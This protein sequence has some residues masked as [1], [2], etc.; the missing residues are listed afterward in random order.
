MT[1]TT[2]SADLVALVHPDLT[3][4][5]QNDL[6]RMIWNVLECFGSFKWSVSIPVSIDLT[7][8]V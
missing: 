1:A 8:R 6:I 4:I 5:E 2:E 3:G 7:V